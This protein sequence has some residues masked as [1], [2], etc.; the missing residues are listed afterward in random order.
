MNLG[1]RVRSFPL[2]PVVC[3]L[4]SQTCTGT[5]TGNGL[6]VRRSMSVR[7]V[8]YD[9]FLSYSDMY[10]LSYSDEGQSKSDQGR[11]FLDTLNLSH[12][13]QPLFVCRICDQNIVVKVLCGTSALNMLHLLVIHTV[14]HLIAWINTSQTHCVSFK[15][16]VSHF[17]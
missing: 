13:E 3:Y 2:P 10:Y 1:M 14:Y 15:H 5:S 8:L 16:T 9:V 4:L 12:E 11:I 7:P 17:K 6:K